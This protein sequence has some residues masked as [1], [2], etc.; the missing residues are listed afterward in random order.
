MNVKP[1]M[2]YFPE[3]HHL[4]TE[5]QVAILEQ[6]YQA[7]F[8]PDNKLRIWRGNLI[9]CAILTSLA[10]LLILVI[11]P[12]LKFSP[13]ITATLMILIVLPAFFYIQHKRYI[14][15]LRPKVLELYSRRAAPGSAT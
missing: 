7:S 10:M 3:I 8:G 5:E 9:S 6:A 11:G 12:L 13:A 14:N 4:S 1:L 15:E 2:K